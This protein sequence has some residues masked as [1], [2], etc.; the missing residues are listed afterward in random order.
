MVFGREEDGGGE[1]GRPSEGV[2]AELHDCTTLGLA[3]TD[4]VEREG[5]VGPDGPED[6][7]FG[8]VETKGGDSLGRG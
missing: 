8:E 5:A 6:G 1:G 3:G 2:G 7:G 4:V